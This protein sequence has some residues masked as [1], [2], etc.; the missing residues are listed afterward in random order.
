MLSRPDYSLG[1]QSTFFMGKG[2]YTPGLVLCLFA[3]LAPEP[4]P[5]RDSSASGNNLYIIPEPERLSVDKKLSIYKT[6]ATGEDLKQRLFPEDNRE[7]RGIVR[8]IKQ[9]YCSRGIK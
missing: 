4:I 2:K 3:L 6:R 7:E 8:K 5:K 9:F 1:N